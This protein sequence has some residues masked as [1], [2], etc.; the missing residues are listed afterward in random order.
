[1]YGNKQVKFYDIY[2][3]LVKALERCEDHFV[4][5]AFLGISEY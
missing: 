4:E 2:F 1:M 3:R 5:E